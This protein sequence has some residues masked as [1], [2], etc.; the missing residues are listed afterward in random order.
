MRATV[1]PNG[2]VV[3]RDMV[4]KAALGARGVR[5]H[6]EEG[7]EATPAGILPLRRILYRADKGPP[8]QCAVPIEPIGQDDGWCDD[9]DHRDYNRMVRLPFDGR[10]E[11][12]WRSDPLYDIVGVLGWND[13][14][15]Q[16]RRGSAIFLHV[17][18]HDWAPTQG[19]VA[20]PLPDLRRLL[21]A[22]MTELHVLES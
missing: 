9:P 8:P 6:K 21:A 2:R 17:A 7:D 15:V 1:H 22:G 13:S 14:P 19:C 12:L 11:E 20:L 18:R 3:F 10:C 16:K 5:L 4:F